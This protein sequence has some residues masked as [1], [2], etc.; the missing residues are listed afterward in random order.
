MAFDNKAY[1]MFVLSAATYMPGESREPFLVICQS[2]KKEPELFNMPP[3]G[4]RVRASRLHLPVLKMWKLQWKHHIACVNVFSSLFFIGQ[5][6]PEC[7]FKNQ[8]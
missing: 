4:T 3:T 1:G 5:I 8:K 7:E 2:G 6:L